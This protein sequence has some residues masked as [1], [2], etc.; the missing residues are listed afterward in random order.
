MATRILYGDT[1]Q[2]VEHWPPTRVATATYA[3][4]RLDRD[5]SDADRVVTSG[6]ATVASTSLTLTGAAG[7]A[8]AVTRKIPMTTTGGAI[9]DVLEIVSADGHRETF[10]VAGINTNNYLMA[11]H[12]LMGTY[13]SGDTVQGLRMSASFPDA[14]AADEDYVNGGQG[15]LRV[16]WEYTI[17][18]H[19]RHVQDLIS[20]VRVSDGDIDK[21]A[22]ISLLRDAFPD[23]P[24]RVDSLRPGTLND[25]A[26]FCEVELRRMLVT[27]GDDPSKF[28]MGDQGVHALMWRIMEH[29]S[30]N[31]IT[32]GGMDRVEWA[33]K[34]ER[35]FAM[36]WAGITSGPAGLETADLTDLEDTIEAS[37]STKRRGPV[38]AA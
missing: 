30:D 15:P 18:G 27:R 4:E 9:G 36:V 10:E 37:P 7:P 20:I 24:A 8:L 19:V 25:W 5:T 31:S 38:F 34:V 6:S 35:K 17:G 26:R 16:T 11:T 28:L 33:T 13:A 22:A 2:E 14:T 12:P 21:Q 29:A 23:I 32:P 1:S 3:L